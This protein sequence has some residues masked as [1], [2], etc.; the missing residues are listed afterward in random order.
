[1]QIE[2]LF[3]KLED[4][5]LVDPFSDEFF[6]VFTQKR[7]ELIKEIMS[8]HPTSIR[9]LARLLDRNIKNVFDDLQLLNERNIVDFVKEGRRKMPVH[10][11][12]IVS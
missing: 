4:A 9:D 8:S 11:A 10:G 7:L 1:M 12:S 6:D 2:R 5:M 3:K